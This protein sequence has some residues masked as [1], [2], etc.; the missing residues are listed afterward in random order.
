MADLDKLIING[1][2]FGGMTSVN[3]AA[4]DDRFK[5]ALGLDIWLFPIKDHPEL[6]IKIPVM[7]L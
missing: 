5:A 2:S 1:H 7:A 6:K 4:N 3:V